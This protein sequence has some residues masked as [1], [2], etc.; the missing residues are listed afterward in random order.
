VEIPEDQSVADIEAEELMDPIIGPD[1]SDSED[2]PS[3]NDSMTLVSNGRIVDL[4]RPI[5]VE[6]VFHFPFNQSPFRHFV[7]LLSYI[8]DR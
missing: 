2:K 8:R 5:G 7:T 4:L 1:E 3:F 6:F